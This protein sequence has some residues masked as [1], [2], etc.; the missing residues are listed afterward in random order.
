MVNNTV[1]LGFNEK[2]TPEII[3]YAPLRILRQGYLYARF[4]E[5]RMERED[6]Q[7]RNFYWFR[8]FD[9]TEMPSALKAIAK[10]PGVVV[11]PAC[12]DIQRIVTRIKEFND[13]SARDI[14]LQIDGITAERFRDLFKFLPSASYA[15][16]LVK[17]GERYGDQI[18]FLKHPH[19]ICH[20]VL[21]VTSMTLDAMGEQS[22]AL[23]KIRYGEK[24][25]TKDKLC[26]QH[27][28]LFGW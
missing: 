8:F 13:Y 15:A 16:V 4:Q 28:C 24:P 25:E 21:P 20:I 23:K 14:Y 11:C 6:F 12:G 19:R 3:S 2:S 26:F 22:A 17:R 18:L 5:Y 7:F 10:I 1:M 9:Q 27:L